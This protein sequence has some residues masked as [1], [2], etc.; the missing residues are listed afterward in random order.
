MHLGFSYVGLVFL[1]MLMAPNLLWT[2]RQP[3]GYEDYVNHESKVFL[4]FERIGEAAVTVL[5]LIFR[6]FNLSPLSPWSLWLAGSFAL[7]ALYE[8][9]WV[10]YF[11]S[12]QTMADFYSSILGIPVAGATLPVIACLLLAVYGRNPLLFVA[13]I[14]LGIGHIGIHLGHRKELPKYELRFFFEFGPA[15]SPLWCKNDAAY[16]R[17]GVG[18]I[19]MDVL[20]ISKNLQSIL[21]QLMDEYQSS[22]AWDDPGGPSPWSDDE[23]EKFQRRAWSA[24]LQIVSEL[25]E[26]FDVEFSV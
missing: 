25:G 20:G 18:P 21:C 19:N 17:F 8:V 11:R 12:E 6:D 22:L 2:K 23:E 13:G 5:V 24:Y 15:C 1:L 14:V 7:M 4:A 26:S 10:R 3:T 9:W 16:K